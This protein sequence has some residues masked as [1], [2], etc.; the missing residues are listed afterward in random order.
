L[1]RFELSCQ[2]IWHLKSKLSHSEAL[3]TY[4]CK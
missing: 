1:E 2:F 3:S 4:R